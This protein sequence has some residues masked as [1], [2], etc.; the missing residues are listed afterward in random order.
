[1]LLLSD[2]LFIFQLASLKEI[3]AKKDEEIEHLHHLKVNVNGT[4]RGMTSVRYGSPSPRR[5]SVE[6]PRHSRRLSGGKASG[7]MEKAAYDVDNCSEQSDKHSEAGS[8]QSLDEFRHQKDL[9]PQLKLSGGNAGPHFTEDIELLGFGD[10]DSEERLSDIS[11]GGLSMGTETDGSIGSVVEYT[12]F[13][14]V[15]KPAENILPERTTAEK[16][17][18]QNPEK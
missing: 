3:V 14:E 1:L 6:T 15:A 2:F 9:S 5:H 12:L 8:Q 11:D 4:M 7:C 16:P 18:I 17:P 10:A 13:P